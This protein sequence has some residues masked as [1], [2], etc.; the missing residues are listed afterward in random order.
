MFDLGNIQYLLTMSD[1]RQLNVFYNDN[2][3]ICLSSTGWKRRWSPPKSIVKSS[4]PFYSTSVDEKDSL[5][6]FHQD[7]RGDLWHL[8]YRQQQ[9]ERETVLTGKEPGPYDKCPYI[10]C[11]NGISY[12]FYVLRYSGK[13]L[14]SYQTIDDSGIS[15]PVAVDYIDSGIMPYKVFSGEDGMFIV[16]CRIR[17]DK[18][19][20]VFRKYEFVQQALG[21]SYIIDADPAIYSLEAI[22]AH[23]G[24][25]MVC[26]KKKKESR[27][28]LYNY[29][30]DVIDGSPIADEPIVESLP[31]IN[32]AIIAVSNGRLMCFWSDSTRLTISYSVNVENVWT[33]PKSLN[34][35]E[36]IAFQC[37]SIVGGNY[38][39]NSQFKIIP[40]K[41]SDGIKLALVDAS[42]AQVKTEPKSVKSSSSVSGDKSSECDK[43]GVRDSGAR[44]SGV[45]DA[46]ARE[47]GA[48][49][50]G[51]G[52]SGAWSSETR[53]SGAWES[54]ARGAG[55][56]ES[57]A[58]DSGA[59]E[60]GAWDAGAGD[61]GAWSSETRDTEAWNEQ[62][63]DNANPVLNN[64]IYG[65]L[66]EL[67]S[68]VNDNTRELISLRNELERLKNK[69]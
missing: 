47:S 51:A 3:G 6:I 1:G 17:D 62:A 43:S 14:F 57:G 9:W 2:S 8:V 31:Q 25:L 33:S 53:E 40:G 45:R 66:E 36:G 42:A 68:S 39:Y 50:A 49:D 67:Q 46:G 48:W 35:F 58:R 19:Q 60:S 7:T 61:S 16:Y 64:R 24:K 37:F 13:S 28:S 11:R 52:D 10:L 55:A 54:G 63:R 38:S 56:R 20:Y 23:Q 29:T 59:R 65:V 41:Y 30:Y 26:L 44:E 32:D 18:K 12:L 5:H 21:G 15:R 22:A 27:F 69:L 34:W 4:L